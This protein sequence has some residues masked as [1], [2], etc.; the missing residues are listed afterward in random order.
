MGLKS[1]FKKFFDLD[2]DLDE[3]L[4]DAFSKGSGVSQIASQSRPTA[5]SVGRKPFVETK[6]QQPNV[7]N[8][9]SV[10]QPSKVMLIE[11]QGF[12]DVQ[13][14]TDH[15][16]HGRPVV[17]NLH[18]VSMSEAK[19]MVDFLSGAVYAIDGNIQKL[20]PDTFICVPDNVDI[21]GAISEAMGKKNIEI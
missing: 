13:S 8:L 19:R 10:H 20:S 5:R 17:F 6:S 14:M 1:T 4:K 12:N 2:D 11:P 9:K 15:L 7:V 18:R 3:V 21:D 16:K